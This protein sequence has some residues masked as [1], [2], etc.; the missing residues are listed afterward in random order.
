M[1]TAA[2][3]SCSDEEGE[4]SLHQS[5]NHTSSIDTEAHESEHEEQHTNKQTVKSRRN[6][7]T[8]KASFSST[9]GVNT[10]HNVHLKSSTPP[11]SKTSMRKDDQHKGQSSS[12]DDEFQEHQNDSLPN[13][14]RLKYTS[15]KRKDRHH[16]TTTTTDDDT[17][18]Q[19]F[20]RYH[21][22]ENLEANANNKNHADLRSES[23]Y[24]SPLS[25]VPVSNNSN[26]PKKMNRFQIKS[27]R[28]SQQQNIFA[29]AS[30]AK[31]SNDDDCSTTTQ[32]S[33]ILMKASLIERKHTNTPTTDGENS[34]SNTD[35]IVNGAVSALKT[36][37]NGSSINSGHKGVR[38]HVQ[39]LKKNESAAEE[40]KSSSTI[41]QTVTTAPP[42]STASAQGEV[43]SRESSTL[44][45]V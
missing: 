12:N 13:S 11:T 31:S 42:S 38:F 3:S 17:S 43:C 25:P 30:A 26:Q 23:N 34:V 15:S 20:H 14:R 22:L 16:T 7:K 6:A 24:S 35:H 10:I 39:Q 5:L 2:V 8:R 27:I 19:R 41:P 32:R 37:Q 29:Q 40:E 9:N 28:K 1:S 33:K 45:K 4:S 18:R 21:P 36:V 44:I